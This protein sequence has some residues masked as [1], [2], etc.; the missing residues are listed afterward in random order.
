VSTLTR[1]E[2]DK[3]VCNYIGVSGGY[4]GDFSYRTHREFYALLELDINPDT[5]EGTTRSRFVTILSR[6]TPDLQARIL[7]GILEKYPVGSAPN[8]TQKLHDE[9]VGWIDRLNT[10]AAV[11]LAPLRVTSAVVER[12]LVDAEKLMTI[13]G[14]TSGVDRAHTA[15]HGYLLQ[16]CADA[17]VGTPSEPSVAQ[18]FKALRTHHPAFQKLGA[19]GEDIGKMLGAMATVV[20]VLNPLRNKASVAHPNPQLL[21][22]PEAL[23]VINSVRTVLNYL[24]SKLHAGKATG[25]C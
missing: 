25:N 4:L 13:T 24:D 1:L 15:L 2:I 23:L 11:V 19:R 8:R 16:V 20:D 18:L 5:I 17:N 10:G 21:A 22:E 3:L 6:A 14:A 7:Q 12:A 9:I